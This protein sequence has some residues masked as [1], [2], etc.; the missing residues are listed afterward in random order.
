MNLSDVGSMCDR[1]WNRVPERYPAVSLD[2]YIIMP[3][4]MHAILD[5]RGSTSGTTVG[6]DQRVRPCNAAH[7]PLSQIV[8]WFKTMTTNEYIRSVRDEGWEPFA[9]RLWQRNYHERLLRSDSETDAAR[10][11]IR[12]NPAQWTLD[13]SDMPVGLR[14]GEDGRGGPMCPPR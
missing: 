3:D 13:P 2:E 4:H 14:V 10:E 7:T 9:W 1:W 6:A 5:L 8:R 11:Y 12:T